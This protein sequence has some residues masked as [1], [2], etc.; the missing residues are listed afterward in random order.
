MNNTR[1]NCSLND[2][3]VLRQLILEN[4]DLP[5][6]IFCGED[7]WHDNGWSYMMAYAT[8]GE[9][10]TLALYNDELWVDEDEYRER[11]EDDLCDKEEYA[12]LSN[13]EWDE[14]ID[15]KMSEVEFVKAIV[16]WVG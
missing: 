11:L 4:P 13:K 16:L 14:M 6:L 7:A 5:L 2:T 10:S 15:K 12:G 1:L 8:K 3:T 9:I